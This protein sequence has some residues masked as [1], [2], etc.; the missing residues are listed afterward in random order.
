[1]AWQY[2]YVTVSDHI[3]VLLHVFIRQRMLLCPKCTEVD[4]SVVSL[5]V[6]SNA[7]P[8]LTSTRL[9][10]CFCAYMGKST[11]PQDCSV[12][13]VVWAKTDEVIHIGLRAKV[14][15]WSPARTWMVIKMNDYKN[16]WLQKLN[17]TFWLTVYQ[18]LD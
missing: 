14:E 8:N 16:E 6:C 10:A 4:L 2:K 18:I 11:R 17:T 12:V 3:V 9:H 7:H 5:C 13:I 15:V 1:M